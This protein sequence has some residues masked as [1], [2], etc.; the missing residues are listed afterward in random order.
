[1]IALSLSRGAHDIP[2]QHVVPTDRRPDRNHGRVAVL[3]INSCHSSKSRQ[4]LFLAS[5]PPVRVQGSRGHRVCKQC[6]RSIVKS[7]GVVNGSA[8]LQ[9]AGERIRI[10]RAIPALPGPTSFVTDKSYVKAHMRL[11]CLRLPNK[12]MGFMIEKMWSWQTE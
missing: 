7:G 6:R 10:S 4:V 12:A 9:R 8:A 2:R 3:R 11:S 1:M 5:A